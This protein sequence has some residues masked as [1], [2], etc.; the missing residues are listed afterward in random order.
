MDPTFPNKS[1]KDRDKV[2]RHKFSVFLSVMFKL[3]SKSSFGLEFLTLP[4]YIVTIS[5][6]YFKRKKVYQIQSQICPLNEVEEISL[7][8]E[9]AF[10]VQIL[11][12]KKT[13]VIQS[14]LEHIISNQ[15]TNNSLQ[16][17]LQ[18]VDFLHLI[19]MYIFIKNPLYRVFHQ[20]CLKFALMAA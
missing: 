12:H 5:C 14:F 13:E 15:H 2:F 10:M 3:Y 16:I 19:Q 4:E 11:E 1:L 20:N 9:M 18:I 7:V 8:T 17:Y 6:Q